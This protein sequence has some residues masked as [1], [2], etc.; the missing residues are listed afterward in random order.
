MSARRLA[1]SAERI[2]FI[3]VKAA[4]RASWMAG[5]ASAVATSAGAWVTTPGRRVMSLREISGGM[6]SFRARACMAWK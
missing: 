5:Q 1:P 3:W 2:A 6:S 4:V